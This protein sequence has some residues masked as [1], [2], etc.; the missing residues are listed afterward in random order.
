LFPPAVGSAEFAVS[1]RFDED[2]GFLTIKDSEFVLDVNMWDYSEGN[3]LWMVR[4]H[5]DPKRRETRNPDGG[6]SFKIN[7]DGTISPAHAEHLVLGVRS[8][9][10]HL[11]Y[12][13]D[14]V[15][16]DFPL[17]TMGA[18]FSLSPSSDDNRY[19][20]IFCHNV[21]CPLIFSFCCTEEC[22]H[23]YVSKIDKD[24]AFK[25]SIKRLSDT[26]NVRA[27]V[28]DEGEV[29]NVVRGEGSWFL[30]EK[31]G[32]HIRLR[33]K[34]GADDKAF[35]VTAT[36][37]ADWGC[38]TLALSSEVSEKNLLIIKRQGRVDGGDNSD[39]ESQGGECN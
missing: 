24:G 27:D 21:N 4:E 36:G 37:E 16:A 19:V 5:N 26:L 8:N 12:G 11:D 23:W 28:A 35:Y 15:P 2:G 9:E 38:I 13:L 10:M 30:A 7:D 17:P 33:L 25:L 3:K 1:A 14:D 6:R 18:K 20:E 31:H 39:I 29:P 22:A 32:D 34:N